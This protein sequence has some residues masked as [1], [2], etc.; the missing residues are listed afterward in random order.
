MRRL[1]VKAVSQLAVDGRPTLTEY[2]VGTVGYGRSGLRTE[3]ELNDR[4]WDR[5]ALVPPPNPPHPNRPRGGPGLL[6]TNHVANRNG[7]S[8]PTVHGSPEVDYADLAGFKS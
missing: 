6:I 5:V 3:R 1:H 4:K 7:F 2:S 8:D